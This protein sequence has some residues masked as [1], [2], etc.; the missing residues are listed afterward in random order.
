MLSSNNLTTFTRDSLLE[1]FTA[2]ADSC[3]ADAMRYGWNEFIEYNKTRGAI[4]QLTETVAASSYAVTVLYQ[5]WIDCVRLI[6]ERPSTEPAIAQACHASS[7][8]IIPR[9][10]LSHLLE[11]ME[12]GRASCRERV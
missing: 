11:H 10:C 9:A 6:T 3:A 1:L 8:V 2:A 12:I 5:P 4:Y 7:G